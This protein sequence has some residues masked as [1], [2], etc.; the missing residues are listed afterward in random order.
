MADGKRVLEN[1]D[2]KM[3]HLCFHINKKFFVVVIVP[4]KSNDWVKHCFLDK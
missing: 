1:I 2:E 3:L 4:F